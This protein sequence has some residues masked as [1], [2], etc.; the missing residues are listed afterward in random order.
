MDFVY[1]LCVKEV[2]H[3]KNFAFYL[4]SLLNIYKPLC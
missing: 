2:A 4:S 3:H 1:D